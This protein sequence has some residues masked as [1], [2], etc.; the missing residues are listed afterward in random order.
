MSLDKVNRVWGWLWPVLMVGA[1]L[2]GAV[3]AP[4]GWVA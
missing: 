4:M 2:Y 3:A 1:L